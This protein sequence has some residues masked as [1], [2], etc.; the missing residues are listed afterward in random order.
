MLNLSI[1]PLDT[2][3]LDEV[4]NDIIE[5]QNT[6]V[7]THAMFMMKFNPEGTPAVNK[8]AKQC[9]SYDLFRERLDKAGAKH[10]V[11]VQATL[12]H[13]T[14]PSSPYPFQ[15]SVFLETGEDRV[16]TCCPLDP[17]F[18]A[19][20]KDQFRILAEHHP[21]VVMLDDDLGLF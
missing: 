1:M 13:I 14:V 7:S 8:A 4:V 3:H 17:N 9:A 16:V 20:I 11:L 15:P 6:G 10:G 18:R 2:S 19:Y 21:S 12:G 5:Q